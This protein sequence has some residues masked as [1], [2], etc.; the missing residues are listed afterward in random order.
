MSTLSNAQ[1]TLLGAACIF[2]LW[3]F[4]SRTI[5]KSKA[6]LTSTELQT[7]KGTGTPFKTERQ[8]EEWIPVNFTYPSFS[9]CGEALENR[10]PSRYR[11]FRWGKYN[12]NMGIRNMV[13]EDWIEVDKLFPE[14][15]SIRMSRF[16]DRGSKVLNTLPPRPGIPGGHF[17]AKELVYELAEFLSR[18]YPDTYSVKR[19]PPRSGD[20]G[21]LSDGQI[22]HI[23]IIPVGVTHD[24][25]EEDPMKVAALLVEDDLALMVEGEDG[26]YYFQA[27]GILLPGFWRMEDKIGLPLEEIHT[28]GAVPQYRE[29]LHTSLARFFSRLP[30]DKPVVRNNYFF[31]IVRPADDPARIAS[32]DP[33]E[34]AWSDSTNGNEDHFE[35]FTKEP[36]L[37]AQQSGKVQFK[38]PTP[39][40]TVERI[41]LRTERQSL[42]RLPR[43]GAIVFTIRTYIFAVEDL[44]KEPGV[45]GRMASA[46]RSWPE[47]VQ[48]YKGERLYGDTI[49]PYL[50]M[51]HAEQIRDGI[52]VEGD[53]SSNYPY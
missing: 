48:L 13:W 27:G 43:S 8:P 39:T 11:P 6:E 3:R 42:R 15:H 36:T 10:E 4:I 52:A 30:V 32:I 47:D 53:T 35:Q 28:R 24:L 18:R 50:D 31:Q 46:I 1:A 33:D 40:D 7:E 45:P 37:D 22:K 2:V 12:I 29:K 19:H 38:P 20:F 14:L 16:L 23:T 25:D 26:R 51:K 9:P 21:W 49:L 44:V 41:R 5:N 34:L 17:A